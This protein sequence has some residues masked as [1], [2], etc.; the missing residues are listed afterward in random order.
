MAIAKVSRIATT[1]AELHAVGLLIDVGEPFQRI[2]G[3]D[4]HSVR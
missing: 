2:D 4:R 3:R 1:P